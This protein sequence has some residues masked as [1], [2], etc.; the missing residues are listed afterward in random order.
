[1]AE[2]SIKPKV[3]DPRLDFAKG[4]LILLVVLG[5]CVQISYR[6]SNEFYN[7][8]LFKF[9]YSFHMP[10]FMMISGWLFYSSRQRP[11]IDIIKIKIRQ[12]GIP[13]LAFC[14][15]C[16]TTLTAFSILTTDSIPSPLQVIWGFK[17]YVVNSHTMW[18]LASVL[19]NSCIVAITPPQHKCSILL[20][21]VAVASL[22]IP[23]NAY[24]FPEFVYMFPF[25]LGGY[26]IHRNGR[27]I[28]TDLNWPH[29]ILLFIISVG[30]LI[31]FNKETYIY[32]SK[33][34]L[35]VDQPIHQL[36]V[37]IH[38]FVT[39][40]SISI[41][42]FALIS[43][44]P[45]Q[46]LSSTTGSWIS[47]CGKSSLAIYGFQNFIIF[48]LTG[49]LISYFQYDGTHRTLLIASIACFVMILCQFAICVCKRSRILSCLFC[50]SKL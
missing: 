43:K 48:L 38:R 26:Y 19:I 2:T 16:Y 3:R 28:L 33:I 8:W 50:G 11:F 36:L 30:G 12:L 7:N 35:I 49:K 31:F 29:A 39:G 9:I 34:S 45:N 15:L 14:A 24:V 20:W 41:L 25:F 46:V 4:I 1:M 23:N 22:F 10:A 5:H 6:G 32:T 13:F 40:L 27:Y 18:F 37:D 17:S 47:Q 21:G 44:I 42:L